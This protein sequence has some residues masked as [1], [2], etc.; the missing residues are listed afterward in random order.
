[1]RS[2]THKMARLTIW[3]TRNLAFERKKYI[4]RRGICP[5]YPQY[6]CTGK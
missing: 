6:D 1:M 5:L 2:T 3:N 4:L